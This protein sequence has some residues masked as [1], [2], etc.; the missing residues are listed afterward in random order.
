M[1]VDYEYGTIKYEDYKTKVSC[2]EIGGGKN[3]SSLLQ[4]TLCEQNVS[5]I[6][7]IVIVIDLS[8]PGNCIE[9]LLTWINEVRGYSKKILKELQK[10]NQPVFA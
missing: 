10:S 3:N 4:A 2:Y 8:K 5:D 7:S 1:V 9:N 6:A